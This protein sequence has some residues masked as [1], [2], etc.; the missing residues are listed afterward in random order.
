VLSLALLTQGDKMMSI[1]DVA[2]C[3]NKTFLVGTISRSL[4]CPS[5]TFLHF[6]VFIC[7]I[8]HY[9]HCLTLMVV[10]MVTRVTTTA[11]CRLSRHILLRTLQENSAVHNRAAA[12]CI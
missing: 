10:F 4:S 9:M 11:I 2:E 7:I 1:L 8:M 5:R 3:W 6:F 12:A